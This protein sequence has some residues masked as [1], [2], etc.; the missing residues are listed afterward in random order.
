MSK[1]HIPYCEMGHLP[2]YFGYCDSQKSWRK[3]MKRIKIDGENDMLSCGKDAQCWEF[4]NENGY[5]TIIVCIDGKSAKARPVIQVI[6]LLAH[7]CSHAIDYIMSAIG[8]RNPST[9]FKA[10]TLQGLIQ[11]CVDQSGVLQ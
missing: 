10:Y 4:S 5:R 7:E 9:E 3:E 2:I 8:E 1:A 6:G 11:F